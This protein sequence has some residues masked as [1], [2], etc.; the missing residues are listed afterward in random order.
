[1]LI[2]GFHHQQYLADQDVNQQLKR[3]FIEK[4]GQYFTQEQNKSWSHRASQM[5]G[6]KI[7]LRSPHSQQC[8]RGQECRSIPLEVVH[9]TWRCTHSAVTCVYIKVLDHVILYC[10]VILFKHWIG[11]NSVNIGSNLALKVFLK[12][13]SIVHCPPA[14]CLV[15]IWG[16]LPPGVC[17]HP[18]PTNR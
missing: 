9:N 6:V 1:M 7:S 13:T 10:I 14:L 4:W 8:P 5:N 3:Q 16:P 18:N 12:P 17:P 11:T 2:E 15:V